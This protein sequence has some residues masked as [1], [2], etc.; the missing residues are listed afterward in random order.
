VIPGYGLLGPAPTPPKV[1]AAAVGDYLDGGYRQ[2]LASRYTLAPQAER[3]EGALCL[4]LTQSL[5]HSGKLSTRSKGLIQIEPA[6]ALRINPTDAEKLALT[7]GDRVRLSNR[8]GV[9]T[10]TV[11]LLDRVPQGS[12]WF[13]DHF[14]QEASKLFECEFDPTTKVPA[15]R[16]ASV[17]IAKVT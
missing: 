13:P 17:S 11:K 5:F 4:G 12:V 15:F 9:L 6:G 8:R 1:D 3:G 14:A 7:D 10:T 16:S 2:D